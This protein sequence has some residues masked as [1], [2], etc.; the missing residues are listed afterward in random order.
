V[1][2]I[3]ILI[4]IMIMIMTMIMIM[5]RCDKLHSYMILSNSKWSDFFD[6]SMTGYDLII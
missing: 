1:I 2:I 4:M 6:Y 5:M 3:M